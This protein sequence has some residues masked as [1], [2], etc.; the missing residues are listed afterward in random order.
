MIYKRLSL[1]FES[2]WVLSKKDDDVLPVEALLAALG[3]AFNIKVINSN[4]TECDVII[5]QDGL[6]VATIHEFLNDFLRANY[7]IDISSENVEFFISNYDEKEQELAK[8][9]AQKQETVI[10]DE[11]AKA[12]KVLKKINALIGAA[13]FKK[14]CNEIAQMAP[15]IIKYKTLDVFTHQSY[16]F[17]INPGNGLST[18]LCLFAELIEALGLFSFDGTKKVVVDKI[19]PPNT[20]DGSRD[21]FANVVSHLQRYTSKD[22]K[23]VCIDISEWMTKTNEKEFRDFL[24]LLNEYM[25]KNII[26]FTI[27]F[28]ERE[29]LNGLKK[30]LNDI[31]FIREISFVPFDNEELMQYAKFALDCYGFT[32]ADDA[33]SVFSAR[34]AEEKNDGRFYGINTVNKVV[35][36]MIY[37]KQLYNV[38]NGID[39][40]LIARNE[41]TELATSYDEDEK[42]GLEMLDGFVGMS[43]L[44][45]RVEEIVAQIE[46]SM[47][48]SELG[49]PCIHM[50]FVGNP[51]TG[52]TTVARVIG[53]ILK[54]R[55]VLRNGSFFE[56]SGRDFCG[57]YI[58]ETAPKTAAMCRDAYGSVLFIDEAYTL[59]KGN[60]MSSA[61]YGREAID[62]LIA[63][64]ENHRSDLVVIMAG[65]PD[66]MDTLMKGNAG[67]ESRMPYVIEFPNYT[68]E[69][70]FEIFMLMTRKSFK[71][72]D[73]FEEA[74]KDYFLSL[75]D[76][77]L[78]AK[79]FSNARFVRNLFERTWGKAILRAQMNKEDASVLIKEDFLMASSEKEFKKIMQ[80]PNKTLGFV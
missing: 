78:N 52:K 53:K 63:E 49:M 21:P 16:L 65:Y 61:D 60:G 57:R 15:S 5:Q 39:N 33:W 23:I 13:E 20:K 68:R 44:K 1:T 70:L 73:G 55:G 43:A 24:S 10:E 27:P 34:I 42:S 7:S 17:S 46:M 37:L 19:A 32:L 72:L 18:C 50:R 71:Y 51:G 28:V 56:Y 36:E 3:K 77:V 62:T 22:G 80:K 26:I 69:Q 74:V 40:T 6:K 75:P 67:L 64:M 14:L 25:G 41:I 79:E 59:Y 4:L 47:K 29:I 11:E 76:A 30:S 48:N 58:G 9:V 12:E 2:S 8:P 31:V 45:Q 35:R 38:Q 66:E 54:E